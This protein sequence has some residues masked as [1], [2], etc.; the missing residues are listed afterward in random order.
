MTEKKSI[1]VFDVEEFGFCDEFGLDWRT[2]ECFL[3]EYLI[4]LFR[5]VLWV[6]V[7]V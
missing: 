6:V 2:V 3:F 1:R 4:E 5:V 7:Y